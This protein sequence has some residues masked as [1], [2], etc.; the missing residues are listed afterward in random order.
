MIIR[1]RHYALKKMSESKGKSNFFVPSVVF[2]KL[3]R[4]Q[5]GVKEE[6]NV[7]VLHKLLLL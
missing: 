6:R 3:T 2:P 4:R 5:S 1:I 7:S